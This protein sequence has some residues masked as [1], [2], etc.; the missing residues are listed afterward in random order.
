MMTVSQSWLCIMGR[1]NMIWK[2]KYSRYSVLFSMNQISAVTVYEHTETGL[3]GS[4][5]YLCLSVIPKRIVCVYDTFNID[6]NI[7]WIF[8]RKFILLN[9]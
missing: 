8:Y 3:V 1:Q 6:H 5:S 7:R 9:Y 4:S 2:L